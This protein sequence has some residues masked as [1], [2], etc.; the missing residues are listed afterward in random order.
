MAPTGASEAVPV[1]PG[2]HACCRFGRA[3]E[4][5]H[6]AASF[7]RNGLTRGNKVLYLC[8]DELP[9][10]AAK[11]E[12]WDQRVGPAIDSGQ[13]EVLCAQET[14]L[15]DGCLRTDRMLDRLRQAQE[16]AT[17]DGYSGL[18]VTGEM[19]WALGGAV[20]TD[21]L[22]DYEHRASAVADDDTLMFCQYDQSRFS[23]ADVPADVVLEAHSVDIA[24]ELAAIGPL[25]GYVSAAA[26][27][28]VLRLAGA[29]DFAAAEVV[30]GVLDRH[31]AG[32]I[33]L[34]LA[35]IDFID[36]AGVRSLRGGRGRAPTID[37]ASDAVVKL[38]SLLGW[39]GASGS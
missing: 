26:V 39:G 33:H 37:R 1:R 28:D 32:E 6:L 19:T 27:G 18:S 38:L 5:E 8:D 36:V 15:P 30:S 29:L 13:V 16:R 2:E 21:E 9:D 14:Y 25:A 34:D 20:S 23:Q 35:D 17:S 7:V 24:P 31:F 4:G 3:A 12:S 22:I 10:V 11:L